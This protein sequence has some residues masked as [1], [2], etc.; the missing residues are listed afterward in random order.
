VRVR[1]RVRV[2][3][4]PAIP[5]D[6][7]QATPLTYRSDESP[8]STERVLFMPYVGVLFCLDSVEF[9]AVLDHLLDTHVMTFR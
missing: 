5:D 6:P 7:P 9:I 2:R 3:V 8:T 4:T 1:V